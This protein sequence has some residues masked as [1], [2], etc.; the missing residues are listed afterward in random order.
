MYSGL[1]PKRFVFLGFFFCAN[2]HIMRFC[3]HSGDMGWM[4]WDGNG[5]NDR[6]TLGEEISREDPV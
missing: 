1:L 6:R 5:G 3:F 4:G 2:V